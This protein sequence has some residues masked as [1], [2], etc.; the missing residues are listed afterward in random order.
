MLIKLE[1]ARGLRPYELSVL[2]DRLVFALHDIF[3]GS[4]IQVLDDLDVAD[5]SIL[6]IH[7]TLVVLSLSIKICNVLA[8]RWGISLSLF[9]LRANKVLLGLYLH[10]RI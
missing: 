4:C 7:S 2:E 5:S 6:A 1:L 9:H 8:V 10:E 3:L